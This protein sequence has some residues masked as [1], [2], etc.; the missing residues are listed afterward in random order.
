MIL[1]NKKSKT[2]HGPPDFVQH[3]LVLTLYQEEENLGRTTWKKQ[4]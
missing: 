2:W 3:N 1:I 4:K